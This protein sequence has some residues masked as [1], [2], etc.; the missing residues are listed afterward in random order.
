MNLRW[1]LCARQ[2]APHLSRT[3]LSQQA[4]TARLVLRAVAP[5]VERRSQHTHLGCRR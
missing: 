2:R 3:F 4:A 1:H 5:M